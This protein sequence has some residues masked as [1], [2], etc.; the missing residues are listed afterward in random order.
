MKLSKL[1]ED[2][3]DI[4]TAIKMLQQGKACYAYYYDNEYQLILCFWTD[5]PE[6]ITEQQLAHLL[7]LCSLNQSDIVYTAGWVIP[8]IKKVVENKT[9]ILDVLS[10]RTFN[11][12]HLRT[13][14]FRDWMQKYKDQADDLY[15][16]DFED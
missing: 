8:I 10:N 1:F 3:D 11:G 7:E 16:N 4:N 15:Y 9:T 6:T 5:I 2:S 13:I 12:I 14:S